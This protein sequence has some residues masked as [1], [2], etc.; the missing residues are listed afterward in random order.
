MKQFILTPAAGK[1]LIGKGIA[2]HPAIQ[3]VLRDGTL[4]IVAGTTNGYVAEEILAATGQS[5]DFTRVGFTRGAVVPPGFDASRRAKGKLAGDLIFVQG[6]AVTGKTI[7][8]V[9]ADLKRGDV[10]LKGANALDLQ[11]RQA[12]ILVGDPQL[13]TAGAAVPA[14]PGRRVRMIVP[15]GLEK[16][17][18][19][20]L[21]DL[22][23]AVNGPSAE[24]AGMFVLPGEVFTELDAIATL[25]GAAATPIAAGGAYGAEGCVWIAVTGDA[26]QLAAA[27]GLI[28]SVEC[29]PP[30]RA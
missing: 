10:V 11:R 4:V 21:A 9:V 28:E 1:R 16:R 14:V 22:A 17:V 12:A 30:C 25:T 24:G 15:V 3:Q 7:F 29:E 19:G 20:P 18:P 2:R 13:G 27:Q 23:E 26:E 5:A 6:A 8:D